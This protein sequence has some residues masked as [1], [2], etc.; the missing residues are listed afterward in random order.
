M[1]SFS[2]IRYIKE[3]ADKFHIDTLK[4][5]AAGGS[6]RRTSGSSYSVDRKL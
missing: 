1:D 5:A 6:C 3:H 2:E 4:I